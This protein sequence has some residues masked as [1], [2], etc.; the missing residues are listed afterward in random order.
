MALWMGGFLGVMA[1]FT[2][3]HAAVAHS[4]RVA[5]ATTLAQSQL[6][7]LKFSAYNSIVSVPEKTATVKTAGSSSATTSF[8]YTITVSPNV[9]NTVKNISIDVTW[10]E[11]GYN[12]V[13]GTPYRSVRLETEVNV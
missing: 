11:P 4:S 5:Y 2:T 6:E 13:N 10:Q 1:L 3:C 12:G 8:F 7:A 9:G